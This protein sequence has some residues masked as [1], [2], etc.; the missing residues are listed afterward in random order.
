M[1]TKSL[2]I[3]CHQKKKFPE[4]TL[5]LFCLFESLEKKLERIEKLLEAR[6]DPL[7][8]NSENAEAEDG[9]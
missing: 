2:E 4:L 5:R 7:I 3:F 1:N 9:D 8:Q 6:L